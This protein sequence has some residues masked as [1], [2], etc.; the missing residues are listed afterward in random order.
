MSL[1]VHRDPGDGA[2]FSRVTR[3]GRKLNARG[4]C[5]STTGRRQQPSDEQKSRPH[6]FGCFR[7]LSR[8]LRRSPHRRAYMHIDCPHACVRVPVAVALSPTHGLGQ[9][10]SPRQ[11]PRFPS[12]GLT[13][14]PVHPSIR[15]DLAH[16]HDT[17]RAKESKSNQPAGKPAL[18]LNF[19]RQSLVTRV[20]GS[21]CNR[22][23]APLGC[24]SCHHP[25]PPR[26]RPRQR[27]LWPAL[28]DGSEEND[29]T[30]TT[31]WDSMP[32][33]TYLLAGHHAPAPLGGYM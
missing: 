33:F 12:Y 11:P 22:R 14:E 24:C 18:G 28:Q 16:T 3:T 13:R 30:T 10:R 21:P 9:A 1:G 25:T 19:W 26:R 20:R 27:P 4:S 7:A 17:T 29:K 31:T 6:K 15:R 8:A 32:R 23:K 5:S 2:R